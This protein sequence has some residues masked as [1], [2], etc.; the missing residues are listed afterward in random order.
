M[1]HTVCHQSLSLLRASVFYSLLRTS[2]KNKT[3]PLVLSDHSSFSRGC[4][5]C[6]RASNHSPSDKSLPFLQGNRSP[7]TPPPHPPLHGQEP[8]RESALSCTREQRGCQGAGSGEICP[9]LGGRERFPRTSDSSQA[10]PADREGPGEDRGK[11]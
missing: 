1:G 10:L 5:L 6:V 11:G 3:G 9:V 8:H 4:C 2:S 7:G